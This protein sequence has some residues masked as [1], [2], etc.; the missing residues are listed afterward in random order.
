[1]DDDFTPVQSENKKK[2]KYGIADYISLTLFFLNFLLFNLF[3]LEQ[4]IEGKNT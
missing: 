3:N 1:M 2:K 4:R